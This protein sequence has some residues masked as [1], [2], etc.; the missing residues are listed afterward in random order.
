MDIPQR[1][2]ET[3]ITLSD[4][5]SCLKR[6]WWKV[7]LGAGACAALLATY[8][9]MRPVQYEAEGTFKEKGNVQSPMNAGSL[10]SLLLTG[11]NSSGKGEAKSM[12]LSRKLLER[13]IRVQDLQ[14][15][16]VQK[17]SGL[18]FLKNILDN[19]ATEYAYLMRRQKPPLPDLQLPL[20]ARDI[21]FSGEYP[22]DLQ[23]NFDTESTFKVYDDAK[24]EL[25]R[26]AV[27][28]PFAVE[29]F[30]FTLVRNGDTPM[31]T[32]T[33]KLTL[34]PIPT[35]TK[36]LSKCIEISAEKDDLNLLKLRY[37]HPDRR[38]AAAVLNQLMLSYQDYLRSD[39]KRIA[40][41]QITYLNKRE[42]EM[43]DYL[44]ERIDDFAGKVAAEVKIQGFP[45]SMKAM[46]FFTGQMQRYQQKLF[47]I[48]LELR[49]F[50]RLKEEDAPFDSR[51]LADG[52]PASVNEAIL[53]ILTLKQN[54]DSIELAL[55]TSPL[56]TA[57]DW[58]EALQKQVVE[59][60]E[61]R[62]CTGDA[63]TLLSKLLEADDQPIPAV[64]LLDNP[65]FMVRAWYDR[66]QECRDTLLR[67][68]AAGRLERQSE[69]ISLKEQFAAYLETLL[70]FLEVSQ[71]TIQERLAHQQA[72]QHAFQ[73][74][75]LETAKDLYIAYS[76]ELSDI[77]AKILQLRFLVEQ[78]KDPDFEISSM[79]YVVDD[80]VTRGMIEKSSGL[81]LALQDEANRSI[82]EKD[83]LKKELQTQKR[84]MDLHLNQTVQLLVL[85]ENLLKDKIES[86]Q[87]ATLEL[88]RQKI[89]ILNKQVADTV[90]TH[91]ANMRQARDLLELHSLDL[92]HEMSALPK[93]W[94]SEKIIEQQ[95]RMNAVMV[96]EL[97][98]L[99]ESKNI[100]SNLEMVQSAP[101]DLAVLPTHPV[102]PRVVYF[103]FLGALLGTLMTSA[104][105][106]GR[107]AVRGVPAAQENLEL[108]GA[109]AA[110]RV[111][112][113]D[114]RTQATLRRVFA[115]F[116]AAEVP[117]SAAGRTLLVVNGK[118]YDCSETMAKQLAYKGMKTLLLDL[119]LVQ[120]GREG[121]LQYLRGE[122][123]SLKVSQ[124]EF[125]DRAA[126]GGRDPYAVDLLGSKR[127]RHLLKELSGKYDW[128]V[129][130]VPCEPVG[131]EAELLSALFDFT[132][133]NV[134]DET[135]KDLRR[136]IDKARIH[137]NICF[138]LSD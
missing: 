10:T 73:G 132:L 104:A 4:C 70:H 22:I 1:D 90:D 49:R 108:A 129:A 133:F 112:R 95:V 35:V 33:F 12:M 43:M 100:A 17:T 36:K 97:T 57:E 61:M 91:M 20:R 66:L 25:G 115:L 103:A 76:R 89:S 87:N 120:N 53:Q 59:L 37:C 6:G 109:A 80:P 63:K 58:K 94:A 44:M 75:N 3:L 48:D 74:I 130:V 98:K 27:G 86:L 8:V 40:E 136:L 52:N 137:K 23:L 16:L 79:S 69:W 85:R 54:S 67:A 122:S 138:V 28:T 51:Y 114:L 123:P 125:F 107:M 41:E 11:F 24:T 101:V 105:L 78:L 2:D 18:N 84:F 96:E 45:D 135:L 19:A 68:D 5:V 60:E 30:S 29:Q 50:E 38:V 110:G 127:F 102:R 31:S 124:E 26:G 83:R 39:Q 117:Q 46:E 92:R 119:S 93:K 113:D 72:P 34:S 42:G 71:R 13:V 77:E 47:E 88:I 116:D 15:D 134:T 118:G 128:I 65:R 99:V 32:E 7:F 21:R 62:R 82:K 56:Q 111:S 121:L 9:L 55:R 14:G 106:L 64:A 81:V 131:S 126:S